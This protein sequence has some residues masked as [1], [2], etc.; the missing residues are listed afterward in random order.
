MSVAVLAGCWRKKFDQYASI[1]LD[2]GH[3][4]SEFPRSGKVMEGPEEARRPADEKKV[5]GWDGLME[6]G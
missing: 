1:G 4:G 6:R 2:R 3:G 5:D